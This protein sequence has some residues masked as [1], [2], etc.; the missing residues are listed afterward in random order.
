MGV[1][2]E[3]E[4]SS[5]NVVVFDSIG[6]GGGYRRVGG[7]WGISLKPVVLSLTLMLDSCHTMNEPNFL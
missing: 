6:G 4:P 7:V 3:R 1:Y 2:R 5:L